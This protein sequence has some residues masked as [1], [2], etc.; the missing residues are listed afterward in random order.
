MHAMSGS[1]DIRIMG[2]LRKKLPWTHGVFFVCWLA[3]CGIPIFSGF[4]SKDSIIAG[5]FATEIFKQADLEWVGKLVWAMLMLAA[6][7]TAFYMSRLYFLVF[8]GDETR[9]DD[10]TRHHI[11]ESPPIMTVPLVVLAAGATLIGFIGLP[12]DLFHHPEYNLLAHELDPVIDAGWTGPKF[13]VP[14]HIEGIFMAVS[15][16]VAVL[17][18]GLAAVFY[19]GGYK[20]PARAFGAKFPGFLRLVQDKFRIDELYDRVLIRPIRA[21]SRGL[22]AFVDRIIIDKILVEG[23]GVLVDVFSRIARTVQGGDGQRYMAVFAVGV[24]LLVHFASQP[25]L[26][27]TKLKVTQTGRAVEI[28]ARRG[29]RAPTR[30]LEYAFDFGD[31]RPVVKGASP[32]QRHDYDRPGSYTIH[33]TISDP[34]WGTE[35][36]FK[37]KVEVR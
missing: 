27:F 6:L 30:P 33:V 20:A 36:G 34:S 22:F 2:G 26:P 8:S 28:D 1:G 12:G 31:G 29:N 18:I 15:T 19:R 24:A 25:T 37:E 16:L 14:H 9:A 4:F 35:D 5:A 17:G 7:G 13:E 10:H 21:F 3:I 23:T 11:H 32:E